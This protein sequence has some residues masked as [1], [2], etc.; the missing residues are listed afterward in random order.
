MGTKGTGVS[1]SRFW[2]GGRDAWKD[3]TGVF[4]FSKSERRREE[5]EGAE[6][7]CIAMHGNER[8]KRL[9]RSGNDGDVW[10]LFPVTDS[11]KEKRYHVQMSVRE[12]G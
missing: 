11:R 7:E 5:G 9:N 12:V 4:L 6:M 10:F 3:N 8:E 1:S 2:Q